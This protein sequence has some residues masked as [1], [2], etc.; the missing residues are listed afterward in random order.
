MTTE[1]AQCTSCTLL[2]TAAEVRLCTQCAKPVCAGCLR[3][4]D[5]C[6]CCLKQRSDDPRCIDEDPPSFSGVNE[7]L[8]VVEYTTTD[9]GVL[10]DCSELG[11]SAYGMSKQRALFN[12]MLAIAYEKGWDHGADAARDQIAAASAA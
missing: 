12:L 7:A 9:V 10:A 2:F 5:L 11:M 3:I 1:T 4:D 6:K 8:L